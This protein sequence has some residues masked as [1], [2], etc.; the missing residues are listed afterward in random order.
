[1]RVIGEYSWNRGEDYQRLPLPE[2]IYERNIFS[3]KVLVLTMA[4]SDCEGIFI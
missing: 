3:F 2:K 4:I 1:V